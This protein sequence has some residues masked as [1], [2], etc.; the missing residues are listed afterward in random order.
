[1]PFHVPKSQSNANANASS[2]AH[3]DAIENQN[4]DNMSDEEESEETE[5]VGE[6]MDDEE[7]TWETEY[8]EEDMEAEDENVQEEPIEPGMYQEELQG[9]E[10]N[11]NEASN[12]EI[13][14]EESS[15]ANW[16]TEYIEE[17]MEGE[18]ENVLEEP[19]A[20]MCQEEMQGQVENA[21]E[22]SDEE[23]IEGESSE[24]EDDERKDPSY[25]PECE[26]TNN[27]IPASDFI[28]TAVKSPIVSATCMKWGISSTAFSQLTS[29][30]NFANAVPDDGNSSSTVYDR[31]KSHR[32]EIA[33]KERQ[34]ITEKLKEGNVILGWDEKALENVTK[35][36]SIEPNHIQRMGVIASNKTGSH[37]LSIEKLFSGKVH[38]Y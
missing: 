29:A 14:E 37:L 23:M 5:Y 2:Q 1:M 27:A 32:A 3:P 19:S 22:T 16:E 7:A 30:M 4:E 33:V 18:D 38:T 31:Q 35:D 10:G 24:E 28:K 12:E 25:S 20:R 26:A 11:A 9:E 17:E 13:S 34:T 36:G 15:E 6:N 21:N 8:L